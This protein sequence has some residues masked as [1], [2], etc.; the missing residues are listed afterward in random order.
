[1][2]VCSCGGH[3]GVH[4]GP[5]LLPGPGYPP[6]IPFR[7]FFPE[8]KRNGF[9]DFS[10][11]STWVFPMIGYMQ[12]QDLNQALARAISDD[13]VQVTIHFMHVCVCM[14]VCMYQYLHFRFCFNLNY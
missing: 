3:S 2:F 5:R 7:R 4:D 10:L 8:L 6:K 1:M 13:D 9:E 11:T 14:Y 12:S